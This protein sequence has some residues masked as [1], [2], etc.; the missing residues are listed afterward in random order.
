MAGI[1]DDVTSTVP[2]RRSGRR[3]IGS[4]RVAN[5]GRARDIDSSCIAE[6]D[7]V[8]EARS[9]L[10][11]CNDSRRVLRSRSPGMHDCLI[12][13]A[14]GLLVTEGGPLDAGSDRLVTHGGVAASS[15]GSVVECDSYV[16]KRSD[17]STTAGAPPN[18]GNEPA[19]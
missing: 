10:L 9:A 13:G 7:D 15:D 5:D 19:D 17:G 8:L 16:A 11:A 6:R 18:P 1:V 2:G 4:A 14:S 3:V 12:V